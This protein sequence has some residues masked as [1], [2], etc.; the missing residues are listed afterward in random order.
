M[1]YNLLFIQRNKT[2]ERKVGLGVGGDMVQGGVGCGGE[3]TMFENGGS[4]QYKGTL[5]KIG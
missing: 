1:C 4:R 2:T 3:C 5:H